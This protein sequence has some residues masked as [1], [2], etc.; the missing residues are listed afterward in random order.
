[1][2]E[3]NSTKRMRSGEELKVNAKCASIMSEVNG[4]QDQ[5]NR[6]REILR[7]QELDDLS[8][9]YAVR[10]SLYAERAELHAKQVE[11]LFKAL[12][13]LETLE[14]LEEFQCFVKLSKIDAKDTAEESKRCQ[15]RSSWMK[16]KS[17]L[18]MSKPVWNRNKRIKL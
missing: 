4:I 5:L 13:T 18:Y 6:Q 9:Y 12:E 7:N 16:K 1:M 14:T 17:L 8:E 11:L 10:S 15:I 3:L 2:E